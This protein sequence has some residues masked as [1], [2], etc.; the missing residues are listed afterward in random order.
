MKD[1][2]LKLRSELY[3]KHIIFPLDFEPYGKKLYSERFNRDITYLNSA[4][5]IEEKPG[6]IIYQ[7]TELG[8]EM[9]RERS[10]CYENISQ[11]IIDT[12][13][14]TLSDFI[15]HNAR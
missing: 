12:F 13:D 7:I 8:K 6:S 2:L 11:D 10:R 1:D 4:G 14:S 3:K 9:Q 15:Q 5:I